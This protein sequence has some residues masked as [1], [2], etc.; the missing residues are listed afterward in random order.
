MVAGSK[1]LVKNV[2][3]QEEIPKNIFIESEHESSHFSKR[4]L[5]L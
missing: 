2:K 1:D 3:F 4:E 5:N